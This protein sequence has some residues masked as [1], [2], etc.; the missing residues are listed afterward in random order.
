[1]PL[2]CAIDL[3]EHEE[4]E[5]NEKMYGGISAIGFL[6]TNKVITDYSSA[7]QIQAEIDAGRLRIAHG[8]K[9]EIPDASPVTG[10]SL[11]GCGPEKVLDGYDRTATWMDGKVVPANVPFYDSLSTWS[12]YLLIYNCSEKQLIVVDSTTVSVSSFF[13]VP[14]SKKSPQIWKGKAEWDSFQ[15]PSIHDATALVSIFEPQND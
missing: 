11:R 15:N 6:S 7:T 2:Y 8:I 13:T 9:G 5:C 1:M 4:L 14:S 3:P 12:G 10:E